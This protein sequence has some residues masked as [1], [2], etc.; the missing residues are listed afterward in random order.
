M[1]SAP[2]PPAGPCP[3]S[4][5]AARRAAF[6]LAALAT[7]FPAMSK[8]APWSGAARRKGRPSVTATPSSGLSSL[9]GIWP[10]SWY[11]ATT[12]SA[13]PARARGNSVS[14]DS[15]PCASMP[16]ARASATA[17][18]MTASSSAPRIPCSPACGLSPATATRGGRPTRRRPMSSASS[19][20]RSTLARVT[21]SIASRSER[22]AL[23]WTTRSGPAIS[24][25]R[26]SRAAHRSASI[27]V[28]PGHG[29]PPRRR[30]SLDTGAVTSASASSPAISRAAALA[31]ATAARAPS[32]DGRPTGTAAWSPAGRMRGSGTPSAA[33]SRRK[34]AGLPST[35]NSARPPISG[36][37]RARRISSGPTPPG[38]P[39]VTSTRGLR[40]APAAG[41]GSCRAILFDLAGR[42]VAVA[43]REWSHPPVGGI[44]GSQNFDTAANWA[45]ICGCIRQV[46]GSVADPGAVLAVGCSSMGGGLVLYDRAGREIWA[47]ANGDARARREAEAQLASGMAARLYDL[48]GGWI[49]LA[50]P[51]RLA[52]IRQ[53]RPALWAAGGKLSMIADW[54]V[55]RL[56]GTLVTEPSVGSTSGM[57]ELGARTWS[58]PI[59]DLCGLT[60]ALFPEVAD[61]G[62]VVG[63]VTPEA[64]GQ[65]GLA[66]ATPVTP[67]GADTALGLVGLQ[68]LAGL[69]RHGHDQ[70]TVTGGSFW[71]QTVVAPAA[72]V[73]PAGRLR[74]TCHV[75][76]RQWL[77]EGIG[78]QAGL[79]L[80]WLRD[81]GRGRSRP[82]QV[83]DERDGHTALERLAAGKAASSLAAGLECPAEGSHPV[84]PREHQAGHDQQASGEPGQGDPQRVADRRGRARVHRCVD[85]VAAD[86]YRDQRRHDV[87]QHVVA[88]TDLVP[89][90]PEEDHAGDGDEGVDEQDP[91]RGRGGHQREVGAHAVV[92]AQRRPERQRQ[93]DR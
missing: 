60:P 13:W 51:P 28:W 11:I 78:C 9:T 30:A 8:A 10:W 83:P 32:A 77:V 58:R 52:W 33:A 34:S 85:R 1:I 67:G 48:G 53:H 55:Y 87:E 24:R 50:A 93:C 84:R 69:Q 79:A 59:M 37:V 92:A 35:V 81:S 31:A 7:C 82:G 39:D 74:T 71:K 80:R 18:L 40:M 42:Q 65:T 46:L 54:M 49:S 73:E 17:G 88:L 12:R 23:T 38:S 47:C 61:A 66:A 21:A 63:T 62:T 64:A 16:R 25:T 29:Y 76:P 14:A 43:Q 4:S 3:A 91:E 86:R 90:P 2:P 72:V 89:D 15:G 44:A 27:S 57:F 19:M 56:T 20:V 70:L 68:R 5:L 41:T 26:R 45:L 75:L 6:M 22:W 36:S